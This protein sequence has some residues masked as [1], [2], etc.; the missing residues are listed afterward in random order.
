MNTSATDSSLE[1]ASWFLT[2]AKRDDWFL[3]T[4]KLQQLLFLSQ[5]HYAAQNNLELLMPSLFIHSRNGFIEPTIAKI[6]AAGFQFSA[7]QPFPA[8][9]SSFLEKIWQIYGSMSLRQISDLIKSRAGTVELPRPG[10]QNIVEIAS[11][12]EKFQNQSNIKRNNYAQPAGRKK[13]L[14]SQNGPVV[15]SK[16]QPRKL[17][18]EKSARIGTTL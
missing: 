14:I 5:I 12:V 15:V 18:T 7:P 17:G 1:V 10:S 13:I 6:C 8:K 4:E 16:W 2:R 11:L 3:E 9:I